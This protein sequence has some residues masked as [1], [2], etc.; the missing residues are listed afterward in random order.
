M[1]AHP[2]QAV[3]TDPHS[4][5]EAGAPGLLSR[6][7]R[8][9]LPHYPD[10]GRR[11]SYLAIVVVTTVVLYY[12]L[13][14]QY[15]VATSVITHFHMSYTYFVWV[16]VIG[17]A[18]GA[19]TSLL[20]GLADRW[21]R[22]NMVVWG[23]LVAGLLLVLGMPNAPSKTAYLLLFAAVCFVEGI[24][25]VATPALIRDF[26]PQLGRATAMGYWTMGPVL[27]SL[28]VT[29]VT[30]ST[31][32]SANWQDELR[33]SG[34]AGL[35]VFVLAF[36]GL[37]ELTP[38]LR[39]QI[40]VS[41]HDR[42][43][44]EA[45]ARQSAADE[46]RTQ[47][48]WRQMLHLDVVGA[49]VAI[50]VFLLL[51][52][53][54]VGNFVV[55]FAAN[56]DY[57]Q[58]RTNAL[59]NWY[60]ASNAIALVVV[61]LLSDRLRVRKP[62]MLLGAVGSIAVTSTFA[63]LA[64]HPQ[65]GYYTFAWLFV[66]VGALSGVAYAPW[67][68]S[69]TETVEKRNPAATAT[70]LAVWGWIIR[71]VVAVSSACVPLVVTSASPLVEHGTQVAEAQKEAGPALAVV[72]AHPEL[73]AE[74]AKYPANAVPSDLAARAAREVGP[75]DLA[76]VQKAQPQLKVLQEYGPEV[77]QAAEDG[78]GQWQTWWWIT[79][80]GQVVFVPFIFV[81]VGRWSP[82]KARED[83]LRHR[84]NVDDEVLALSGEQG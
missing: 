56:F 54:A 7:W 77:Q 81:M 82:G 38:A 32:S 49:A 51:Y 40:M 26:S 47:G 41:L 35:I 46:R 44:V 6:L 83:E 27:G 69:F 50:S 61:G 63:V 21:G 55:Y 70:G 84:R 67:M 18:V 66:A 33:Y 58:Q 68:A 11:Y 20:A 1:S 22:A 42:R 52:F 48:L 53:S 13:Y 15:A 31:L 12:E 71:I 73:F 24:V 9:E 14:V 30:S 19:F 39:D 80:A 28:V 60:W 17:N 2:P 74:L 5:P 59:A 34:F 79:V 65:T 62:F 76:R 23:L 8:R 4:R 36:F 29:I 3:G 57:S 10:A 45:R 25:L 72:K 78:P 43:L 75:A 37:R 64:T 16:S